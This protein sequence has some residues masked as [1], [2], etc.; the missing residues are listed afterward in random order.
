MNS[1]EPDTQH[2][3][4]A[5]SRS[6]SEQ[7]IQALDAGKNKR[8]RKLLS[9]M[10][11]AKIA[12]MLERLDAEQRLALWQQIDPA[13]EGR[14]LPHLSISL[15]QQLAGDSTDTPQPSQEPGQESGL[16]NLNHLEAVREALS[17]K[18]LKRVGKILHRMHP[19]KVAGLL[20]A[21][22]PVERLSVWSM[23]D[24]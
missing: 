8:A 23:V 22:P 9:H 18:K 24:T 7:I 3:K 6:D 12:A 17:L 5:P 4:D 20:E 2:A 1:T 15:R 14:I 21:L 19:A 13:R 11:P 16:S 10:H